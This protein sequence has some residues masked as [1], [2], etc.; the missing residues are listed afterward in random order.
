MI[1]LFL[2][3]PAQT[4]NAPATPVQPLRAQY[5]WGYEGPDG[6]GTGTLSVLVDAATG[7]LVLELHGLGERLLLLEGDRAAGY[8]VQVPRQKLD[9]HAPTLAGLPLPFLPEVASPEALLKLLRTGEGTGVTVTK[10]DA[11]GPVKLHWRG[12]DPRGREEQVWL[13]RKRWEGAK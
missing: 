8:R 12:E 10:R 7:R 5:G 13:D 3:V 1:P 9:R 4:E 11:Q 6:E 2:A